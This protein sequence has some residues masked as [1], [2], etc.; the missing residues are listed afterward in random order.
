MIL[1]AILGLVLFHQS[2]PPEP[3][4]PPVLRLEASRNGFGVSDEMEIRFHL[5]APSDGDPV[6]RAYLKRDY[7]GPPGQA[8]QIDRWIDGNLCPAVALAARTL[9][10]FRPPVAYGPD[11]EGRAAHMAPHGVRYVLT[12][13]GAANGGQAA[14]VT[15]DM[16]GRVLGEPAALVLE[17]LRDCP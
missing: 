15:T 5:L 4:T 6:W 16:T 17:Q 10:E 13:L 1:S 11:T 2:A 3:G 9:R 14:T 8:E 12:T 7:R